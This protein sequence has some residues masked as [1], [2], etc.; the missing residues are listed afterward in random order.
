LEILVGILAIAGGGYF[1]WQFLKQRKRGAVC[2]VGESGISKKV[3]KKVEESFKKEKNFWLLISSVLLFAALI[4]IIEF[5]C[6]AVVPLIFAGILADANLSTIL[7][8]SYIALYILFYLL[9][10]III[11]LIA[12]FSMKIWI[13]SP[14]ITQ[15]MTLAA[16][17]ILFLLGIFYFIGL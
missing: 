3:T 16:A 8:L 1:L 15:W 12:V 9:D 7:Y 17:I 2:E 5:P 13:T 11:F 4:T 10:E 14:K 6:S